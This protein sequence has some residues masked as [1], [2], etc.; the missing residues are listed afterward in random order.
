MP[1]VRGPT[2]CWN[3]AFVS[4]AMTISPNRRWSARASVRESWRGR[5]R[6]SRRPRRGASSRLHPETIDRAELGFEYAVRWPTPTVL[7]LSRFI[8]SV[9]GQI[10]TL[11]GLDAES[12]VGHYYVTTAGSPHLEA[13]VLGIDSEFGPHAR[14][15]IEYTVGQ[16]RWRGRRSTNRA[17]LSAGARPRV[18]RLHDVTLSAEGVVPRTATRVAVAYRL[19]TYLLRDDRPDRPAAGGRFN[20]E[21]RQELPYKP[22]RGG[23]LDLVLG[24]R[25]LF[26]EIIDHASFFDELLTVAPPT[27]VVCGVQVGF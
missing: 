18:G 19:N 26:G 4:I 11:F 1:G 2:S 12:E 13:W 15:M 6:W 17:V 21:I 24:V 9:D 16:A 20:L 8:E 22:I 25:S 5:G 23:T 27:R 3:T 10:A 14:A 7:R